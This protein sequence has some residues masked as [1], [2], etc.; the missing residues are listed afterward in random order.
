MSK[1]NK[2]SSWLESVLFSNRETI[3]IVLLLLT[4]FMVY[5]GLKLRMDA[6]FE[7][8]LPTEHEYIETLRHYS[9]EF[10]G[11]N[12]LIVAVTQN[13]GDMFNADFFTALKKANEEMFF[14]HGVARSSVTSILTPNVRFIEVVEDG[15]QGGNVVPAEFRANEKWFPII[16]NNI[17]KSGRLGNLVANDFSGAL[18]RAELIDIDPKTRR[19]LNYQ[20]VAADLEEKIRKTVETDDISVNIIGF[21]K[22]TGDIADGARDVVKFFI[23]TFLITAVLLW[24]YSHSLALTLLPLV[25]AT[26][27]V[28]WQVG[29][30]PLLG[31]GLDPMSILVPFLVFAIGVSH[32]VQ[33]I[34]GWMGEILYGG[35]EDKHGHPIVPALANAQGIS[36]IE[37][38]KRTFRRLIVPGSVALVSDVVGFLTVLLIPIGIIQ[39]MAIAASLGVAVII[40]TNLVLLPILLSYVTLKDSEKYRAKH[41]K[42]DNSRDFLWRALSKLTRTQP[43]LF[44]IF[45]VVSLTA[46]GLSKQYD[47]DIGDSQAGVSELRADAR[48]NVD[49]RVITERFSV[50]VDK[51]T[52][53]IESVDNACVDYEIMDEMDR[54]SWHIRNLPGVQSVVSL[55]DK[56]KVILAAN[57]EG[58]QRWYSISRN[59]SSMGASLYHMGA[60]G[61]EFMDAPCA[62]MPI[63]IY[64]LDHKATTIND[65]IAGI[66]AYQ[67]NLPDDRFHIRLA[68]GNVGIIAATND[69]VKAAQVPLMIWVYTAVFILTFLTFR[70]IGGTL[71]VILPLALVSLLCYALMAIMGIGLKVN[72]LPIVALGV[73]VGVDYAIYIYSRM[74]EFLDIGDTL[75]TAFYKAMRLTGK[76][77]IFT[78]MTLGAGVCTWIFAPLQFQSDMG[79]LL[80]FMFLVNMLGAILILPALARWLLVSKA[81]KPTT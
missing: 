21:A 74:S 78:A 48:Y 59:A 19:P 29:L 38:S 11:G 31:F 6:G 72:T 39:E 35:N 56:Q 46:W 50:G 27:A 62:N 55:V 64:T 17:I 34:S 33:M 18:I 16:R 65:I 73:G 45:I 71:C 42:S 23:V 51:L 40:I 43:S 26:V 8:L 24:L 1:Q 79:I 30:L 49:S 28:V 63:N 81:E 66:N 68:S 22:S 44:V 25:S 13:K 53:M 37:A 7:K 54:F 69:T 36:G 76:P 58:S 32:G 10:G 9:V 47:L 3:L 15:F 75:E 2:K 52:V 60:G 57:N 80:T 61:D 41:Q 20:K 14:L 4:A 77:V 67:P 12:Q 5:N 70:S